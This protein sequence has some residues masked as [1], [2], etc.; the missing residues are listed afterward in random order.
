[1]PTSRR[2]ASRS[3]GRSN[4]NGP[5]SELAVL[6]RGGQEVHRRAADEAGDEAVRGPAVD[7]VR[8]ADLLEDALVEHGDAVPERQRLHLVVGDVDH[9]RAD[10]SVQALELRARLDAELGVEVRERL[11]E[12]VDVRVPRERARERDALPLA[13]G[14]LV[15]LAVEQR[16]AAREPGGLLDAARG[17]ALA[18]RRARGG[19]SRCSRGR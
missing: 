8:G 3:A 19:R 1:M 7:L 6:V 2:S 5:G 9:R 18:A 14:E 10:A 4:A 16:L 15:R 13:A 17:L 12:E 11:V